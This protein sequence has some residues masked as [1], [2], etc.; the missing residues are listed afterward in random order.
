MIDFI[1]K[2]IIAILVPFLG[3][4]LKDLFWLNL[5]ILLGW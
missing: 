5:V 4:N 3:K 1:L 2:K